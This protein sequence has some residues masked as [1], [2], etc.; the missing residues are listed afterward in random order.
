MREFGKV[1]AGLDV[2]SDRILPFFQPA[3][4]QKLSASIAP[5]YKHHISPGFD[6]LNQILADFEHLGD[7]SHGNAELFG[8]LDA[9]K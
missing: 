1:G 7:R 6:S 3:V 5:M 8:G 2:V 4:A 9:P